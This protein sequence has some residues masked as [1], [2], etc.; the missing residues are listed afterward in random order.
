MNDSNDSGGDKSDA[1]AEGGGGP[2]QSQRIDGDA[3]GSIQIGNIHGNVNM[4]SRD[5]E[6]ARRS[7]SG[8]G[9]DSSEGGHESGK[10]VKVALI[11]CTAIIIAAVITAVGGYL[12]QRSKPESKAS[13][14]ATAVARSTLSPPVSSP[15]QS[16]PAWPGEPAGEQYITGSPELDMSNKN[17]LDVDDNDQRWD[18]HADGNF[19]LVG[20]DDGLVSRN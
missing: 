7:D 15:V 13:S 2:T 17:S 3:S 5:A 6:S 11:G 8:S 10:Q 20:G 1:A 18:M 14:A 9:P 4:L 19:D 16:A 12:T